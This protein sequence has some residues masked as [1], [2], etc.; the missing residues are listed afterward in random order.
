[1]KNKIIFSSLVLFVVFACNED[2]L[3]ELPKDA[4]G[5]EP[6]FGSE[7]GLGLYAYSF[8]N[9]LPDAMDIFTGDYI[10]DYGSRRD[11]TL[12]LTPG[13]FSANE[14]SGWSWGE[15][16]NINHFIAN[17]NDESVPLE[18]R[19]HYLGLARFFRAWFYFE[20]V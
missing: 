20:K 19:Q 11:V 15:L 18:I 4:V 16:R 6:V 9:I 10:S 3:E 5:A 8:Y 17:C 12:Y 7:G 1:M 13:A 14:S 2:L